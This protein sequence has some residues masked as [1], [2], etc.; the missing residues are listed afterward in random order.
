MTAVGHLIV[1]LNLFLAVSCWL[2]R[3]TFFIGAKNCHLFTVILGAS[4]RCWWGF[5]LFLLYLWPC[6]YLGVFLKSCFLLLLFFKISLIGI[7]FVPLFVT[8]C[9]CCCLC[10]CLVFCCSYYFEHKGTSRQQ[11][12][13]DAPV[14][15]PHCL[16]ERAPPANHHIS[17]YSN[18]DHTT[19]FFQTW[20]RRLAALVTSHLFMSWA[21]S[22]YCAAYRFSKEQWAVL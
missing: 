18:T 8:V 20:S 7:S 5:D 2:N 16:S 6:C 17:T 1:N 14:L 13:N 4:H 11:H 22:Q 19:A 10:P 12:R 15:Q 9:H 3:A 21:C